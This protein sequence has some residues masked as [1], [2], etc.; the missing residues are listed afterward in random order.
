M[1][2]S[3]NIIDVEPCHVMKRKEKPQNNYSG[4][5]FF[6]DSLRIVHTSTLEVW[7]LAS[8]ILIV[9]FVKRSEKRGWMMK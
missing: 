2:S 8:L 3:G 1:D 5:G 9:E 7:L 6:R 4:R